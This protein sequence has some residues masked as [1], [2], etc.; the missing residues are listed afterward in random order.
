MLNLSVVVASG[1]T[2]TVT[3]AEV[4][5]RC[6]ASPEYAAVSVCVPTVNPEPALG[7]QLDACVTAIVQIFVVPSKKEI[8]PVGTLPSR[9]VTSADPLT[10]CPK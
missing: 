9:A 1:N 7:G 5:P 3:G 6:V 4:D 10:V 8:V 2:V